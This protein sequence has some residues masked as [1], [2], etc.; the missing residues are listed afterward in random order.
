MV[1]L[2]SMHRAGQTTAEI[3][4]FLS[5]TSL[6]E[7]ADIEENVSDNNEMVKRLETTL[8]KEEWKK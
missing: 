6:E 4:N 3:F 2:Q 1:L 7:A 5:R 8:Y